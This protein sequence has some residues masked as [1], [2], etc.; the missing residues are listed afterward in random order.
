MLETHLIAQKSQL[1]QFIT[2]LEQERLL[3]EARN[4]TAL[5][6][7]LQQKQLLLQQIADLDKTIEINTQEHPLIK[8]G[9]TLYPLRLELTDLLTECKQRNE[10]NG[11]AIALSLESNNRFAQLLNSVLNRNNITYDQHGKTKTAS[12]LGKG[13]TA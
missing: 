4:I 10:I 1:K 11:K 6:T 12:R 7:L 3:L 9:G 2:L 8:D 13:F 5:E